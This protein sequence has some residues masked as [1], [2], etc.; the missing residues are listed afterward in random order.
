LEILEARDLLSG[1]HP[2]YAIHP[3]SGNT[4][5]HAVSGPTGTTPAQIRQ[6]YGFTGITFNNGTIAGD[7]AGTTVA[8]VDAYNDPTVASDLNTFDNQFGITT[9]GPTLYQQYGAASSFFKVVNQTGGATLPASDS[10]WAEEIA[11]DVEWAHA[12]APGA[13]ILLVEANSNSFSDLFAAVG[14][15]AKQPGVVAV[16]MSWGGGEFSGETSYD[17]VFRTPSGHAG[18]TFVVSSGDN[19]APASYP[20]TSPNVVSVGG[21]STYLTS[22]GAISSQSAWSGSGGGISTQESQPTYQKGVVT[23]STTKRTNPDVAYDSDPNTGFPVYNSFSFPTA[24]W[25]QFGGTSD[26]APQWAALIAIADEGRIKAGLGSLDGPSQT[27]PMLYGLPAADFH[28]ITSGSSTG[29]PSYAAGPGYDLTTGRG[30]PIAN[31][32]VAGLVGQTTPV[33]PTPSA[34]HF[35]V[36]AAASTSAGS[37]ITVT[38]TALDSSGNKVTGYT[39]SVRLT[40]SDLAALLPASASLTN[41]VGVFTIT[42]KTTGTQSVIATATS[43]SSITGSATVNVMAPPSGGGGGSGSVIENFES[44]DSW[45][46]VGGSSI[47]AVEASYAAHDGSY[48]LDQ[49]NSS[50][51]IYR[52]DAGA[53]LKAGD[54]ASVWLKFAGSADGRAYFGFGANSTGTLSL[55]AAPNTGQLILQQN[56][57]YG[58]TNLAA[59]GQS[60]LANH[61]YRLEVDWGTSGKIVGKLYDSNGTTL[62]QSVS[63][64]TTAIASGGIAFRSI[65][66]D[67]YW[68]TVTVTYAVNAFTSRSL[69]SANGIGGSPLAAAVSPSVGQAATERY[70]ASYV[71]GGIGSSLSPSGEILP[72]WVD[73]WEKLLHERQGW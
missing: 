68:D 35:S 73:P 59:V 54:T 49:Y 72:P 47:T 2:T 27:L 21:T 24:P 32:V 9:T 10:G 63:A 56:L 37:A 7:G 48:G 50:E 45:Y 3:H 8:I 33:S 36:S 4:L 26:A 60:Y 16:S 61:W 14:Y 20:A 23:Q 19:G 29:S 6:A 12:I 64:T 31:L 42:L 66:S 44:S 5:P 57:N 17:S 70:F 38:V 43:N 28:D 69:N 30:T 55:V 22:S 1:F 46:I 58:Y 65:G 34:T 67:K 52:N 15:A 62:L 51:W 18:V 53:Q 71:S 11:L 39:G 25:Q 41:G 13:K 40:S